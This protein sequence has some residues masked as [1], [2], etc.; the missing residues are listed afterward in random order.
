MAGKVQRAERLIQPVGLFMDPSGLPRS[1]LKWSGAW[2]HR[3]QDGSCA[4]G[5]AAAALSYVNPAAAPLWPD[6]PAAALVGVGVCEA[7]PSAAGAPGSSL[8]PADAQPG[9]SACEVAA[10]AASGSPAGS[11]PQP[12]GLLPELAAAAAAFRLQVGAEEGDAAEPYQ[13]CGGRLPRPP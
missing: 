3:I 4:L 9:E 2:G 5:G 6:L 12:A 7:S 8:P 10:A 11:R 13:G 1:L